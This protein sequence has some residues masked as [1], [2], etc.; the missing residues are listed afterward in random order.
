MGALEG[1]GPSELK[2]DFCALLNLQIIT[3]KLLFQID[4]IPSEIRK[5]YTTLKEGTYAA[6]GINKDDP[7][8]SAS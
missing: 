5:K 6:I 1:P 8:N 4:N 2:K 3:E 7:F